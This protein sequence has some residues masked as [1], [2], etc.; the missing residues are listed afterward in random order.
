MPDYLG[1][2]VLRARQPE[3]GLR[4]RVLSRYE[5]PRHHTLSPSEQPLDSEGAR[6]GDSSAGV[7]PSERVIPDFVTEQHPLPTAEP[8]R[9]AAVLP[10][11]HPGRD[12]TDLLRHR[13]AQSIEPQTTTEEPAAAITSALS[14]PRVDAR[15]V[16]PVQPLVENAPQ[17]RPI[18]RIQKPDGAA[19]LSSSSRDGHQPD[20][21]PEPRVMPAVR[22]RSDPAPMPHRQLL[23]PRPVPAAVAP[24]GHHAADGGAP[25]I[26]VT[27]GR[28][29]IRAT[30]PPPPTRKR[31]GQ[32]PAMSLDDY[33]KRRRGASRE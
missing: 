16:A 12:A 8:A 3:L 5:S 28:V 10:T 23:A 21:G 1:Q 15:R 25:V 2:L 26:H 11:A 4:P 13:T 7:N 20:T 29:E 31:A 14:T 30:V 33:L 32:S 17:T 9:R 27:I 24:G 22:Q 6:P 18:V 19:A